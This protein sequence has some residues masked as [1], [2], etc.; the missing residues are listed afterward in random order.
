ME[1]PG[2]TNK[3]IRSFQAVMQRK[4]NDVQKS[5]TLH[6]FFV[7]T[8]RRGN[9]MLACIILVKKFLTISPMMD[10]TSIVRYRTNWKDG[11]IVWKKI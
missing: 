8:T 9:L 5:L 10:C 2:I 6:K 11:Q 1:I 3:K 4:A 7:M